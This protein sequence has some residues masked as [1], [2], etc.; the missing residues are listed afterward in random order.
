MPR[1]AEAR[2]HARRLP[3]G[4]SDVRRSRRH[5][6]AAQAPDAQGRALRAARGGPRGRSGGPGP[7]AHRGHG[8]RGPRRALPGLRPGRRA[9]GSARRPGAARRARQPLPRVVP[10]TA[11]PTPS[12]CAPAATSCGSSAPRCRRCPSSRRFPH[13]PAP[14]R[15]AHPSTDR[16]GTWRGGTTAA[17]S[18]GPRPSSSARTAPRAGPCR[19]ANPRGTRR[20]RGR[21]HRSGGPAWDASSCSSRWASASAPRPRRSPRTPCATPRPRS[22]PRSPSTGGATSSGAILFLGAVSVTAGFWMSARRRT[23]RRMAESAPPT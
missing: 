21:R 23:R 22:S 7:Q 5:L 19:T 12:T 3:V 16:G 1:R 20:P 10:P 15:G 6:G 13:A 18:T 2:R 14:I 4:V 9:R 8:R 11:S 17:R